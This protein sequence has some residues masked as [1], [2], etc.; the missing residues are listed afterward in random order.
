MKKR[1]FPPLPCSP[2]LELTENENK[3]A[4]T[5]FSFRLLTINLQ[6]STFRSH[7]HVADRIA[8]ITGAGGTDDIGLDIIGHARRQVAKDVAGRR[9]LGRLH[10]NGGSRRRGQPPVEDGRA[11]KGSSPRPRTTRRYFYSAPGSVSGCQQA[12]GFFKHHRRPARTPA[13]PIRIWKG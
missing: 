11:R 6:P 2:A 8:P 1:K 4:G 10:D 7:H 9:R 5:I 12:M 3:T 13:P